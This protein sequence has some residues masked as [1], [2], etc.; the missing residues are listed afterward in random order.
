MKINYEDY[1]DDE[2]YEDK[3]N[4]RQSKPRKFKDSEKASAGNSSGK[5]KNI[6]KRRKE[7]MKRRET[8]EYGE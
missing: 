5:K 8:E 2:Y 1:L 3:D 6:R 4:Y 7:K